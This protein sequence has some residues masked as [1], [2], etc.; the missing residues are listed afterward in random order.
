MSKLSIFTLVLILSCSDSTKS[1]KAMVS[2]ISNPVFLKMFNEYSSILHDYHSIIE[3]EDFED[4]SEIESVI[5]LE[6]KRMQDR[7]NIY[8][9]L[10]KI[11]L[12]IESSLGW[13]LVF[14]P[15]FHRV[16]STID[17]LNGERN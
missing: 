7:A 13:S 5:K 3:S 11:Y 16:I 8:D 1:D 9:D 17:R 6:K 12:A 10:S 4:I 15:K 14:E 2:E